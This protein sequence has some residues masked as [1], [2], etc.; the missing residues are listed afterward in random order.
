MAVCLSGVLSAEYALLDYT[1]SMYIHTPQSSMPSLYGS[2][3]STTMYAGA[4]CYA[5]YP[6]RESL[7]EAK[8][9]IN[10]VDVVD[11][12]GFYYRHNLQVK[13]VAGSNC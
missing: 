11:L 2:I 5:I 4:D 12:A 8:P 7:A 13:L 9:R 1:T 3:G 10:R 6:P